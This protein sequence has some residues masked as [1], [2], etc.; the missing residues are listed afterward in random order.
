MQSIVYTIGYGG[1]T[2]FEFLE[3]LS[4]Y[5][6]QIVVDVRRWNKS[7]K[8]QEFSG[9]NLKKALEVMGISYYWFPELGGYRKFGVDV[10][11]YGIASCFKSEGFRA[12]ATYVTT[13]IDIKLI[14]N[15]TVDIVSTKRSVILCRERL[16]WRCHRKIL[17]DFLVVKGFRVL[18]I[19]DINKLIEHKLSKCAV[20]EKSELRYI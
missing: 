6:I 20:V 8:I 17:S 16:P 1:R 5:G 11:D 12:Y 19:I 10:D 2:I 18:H 7:I 14:L 15:K 4:N 3:I 13:R 9:D